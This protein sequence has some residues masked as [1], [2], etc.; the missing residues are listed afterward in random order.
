MGGCFSQRGV[1]AEKR[2]HR[3]RKFEERRAVQP[4][5]TVKGTWKAIVRNKLRKVVWGQ[6]IC[7]NFEI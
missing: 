5:A 4:L 6:I 1:T 2:R 7:S 3:G